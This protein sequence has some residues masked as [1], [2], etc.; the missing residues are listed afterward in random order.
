MSCAPSCRPAWWYSAPVDYWEDASREDADDLADH[1]AADTVRAPAIETGDLDDDDPVRQAVQAS[2]VLQTGIA[3]SPRL[4]RRLR[5]VHALQG[6][7]LDHPGPRAAPPL[8]EL[9]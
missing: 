3:L 8:L 4:P 2:H 9:P 6:K 1:I 7:P 5:P